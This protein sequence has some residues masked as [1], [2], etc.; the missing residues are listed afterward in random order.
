MAFLNNHKLVSRR[1]IRSDNKPSGFGRGGGS[2]GYSNNAGSRS[3]GRAGE[4]IARRN[5]RFNG[6]VEKNGFGGGPMRNK[7]GLDEQVLKRINW[8][9]E[10]LADLRKNFYKPS[11]SVTARPSSDVDNYQRKNEV[12]VYGRDCPSNVFEFNEVGFPSYITSELTRQGFSTPTV[13]QAT[14]WPIAM[15]GR[16]LVGIAQTGSGKTLAY[17]LPALVHITYQEKLKRG[18]GPIVLVLA[19]TRELAQQIQA[20][21]TDFGKRIGIRNTCVFGGAPKRPQQNDLQRGC[22]IVIA[23]PGRLIDFL[24]Q[25]TT[26]LK[27]CSYLVLVS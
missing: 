2:S 26:N 23:T 14:S 8:N 3:N 10:T 17:I 25:E 4:G 1:Y 20:V 24:Q 19:P 16:D 15:S 11:P 21:A 9:Q 6:R 22:E 18:D 13:I 7:N 27:R 12:T 5:D